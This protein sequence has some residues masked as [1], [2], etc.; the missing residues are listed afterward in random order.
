MT[1]SAFADKAI[2]HVLQN[3]GSRTP[4]PDG[5]TRADYKSAE[6]RLAWRRSI[7]RNLRAGTYKPNPV[8]RTYIPKPHKPGELRPLGIPSL[9]EKVVQDMLKRVLEPVFESRFHPHSYGFRLYRSAHHAVQRVRR[10]IQ[11]GYTWVVEGDIKGFFDHVDHDILLQLV[12]REVGDKRI[13]HLIR[14]FLKAGFLEDGSFTVTEEGTPQGG[15]LSPLLG[16]LYL[17]ELDWFVARKYETIPTAWA[18]RKQPYGCFICRYADD[19]V[20]LVRGSREDA[21]ALRTEVSDFLRDTL[22]LELSPEKTLVTHVDEGFDFLGFHIR[23]YQRNGRTVILATPSTK[24]QTT[25]RRRIRGLTQ[26]LERHGGNLWILDLNAYLAGWAEYYRRGNSKRIFSKLDHILW[27][28]IAL[29]MRGRWRRSREKG[30]FGQFMRERL[31]R[32]RYDAQHPQ[33]RHYAAR[34][35][36]HWV[37][38]SK[39]AAFIVDCLSYYPIRYAPC[40][41]QVHPFTPEGRAKVET[42]RRAGRLVTGAWRVAPP[43]KVDGPRVY[44]LLQA[45]LAGHGN[46]CAC[47][48]K[49]LTKADVRQLLYR[50]VGRLRNAYK[51]TVRLRCKSCFASSKD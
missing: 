10:L 30:G 25:F 31:I 21:E 26:G 51:S 35:F 46:R 29:R 48:G 13:L 14:A 43:E 22:H 27:W 11:D 8:R 20:L 49:D 44:G 34:N 5:K 45:W 38:S 23:R 1:W 17:N 36:G 9:T 33:Y 37:D 7:I 40:F 32:Y 47:C 42:Q 6:A 24:A 41:T 39:S 18:R 2:E 50:L 3:R 15:L 4:G 28:M 19:F 16:N 12:Q